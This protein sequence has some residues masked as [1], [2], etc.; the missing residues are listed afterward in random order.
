[1]ND[2]GKHLTKV[3]LKGFNIYKCLNRLKKE[4]GWAKDFKLPESVLIGVCNSYHKTKTIRS[5]WP[6]FM[7]VLKAECEQ[8]FAQQQIESNDKS[9]APE[10][11][12][13]IQGIFKKGGG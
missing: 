8:W 1:M 6:W 12:E 13:L 11:K 7:K 2:C 4:R 9:V 5:S 3:Y 10:I